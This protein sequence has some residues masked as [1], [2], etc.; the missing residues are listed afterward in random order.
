[1]ITAFQA[2]QCGHVTIKL[3]NIFIVNAQE[4]D[5]QFIYKIH[6][7]QTEINS[8]EYFMVKKTN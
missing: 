2:T 4:K 7:L 3:L 8:W 5:L 1:M 6:I